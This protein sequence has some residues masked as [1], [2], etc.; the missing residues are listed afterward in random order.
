[1]DS[2]LI[3]VAVFSAMAEESPSGSSSQP[4]AAAEITSAK[5]EEPNK[6]IRMLLANNP[7]HVCCSSIYHKSYCWHK[8]V[9]NVLF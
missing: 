1:M 5:P 9:F 7:I 3:S 8:Y 4:A 2:V 6:G